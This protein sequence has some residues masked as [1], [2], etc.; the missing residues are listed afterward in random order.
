MGLPSSPRK[1]PSDPQDSLPRGSDFGRPL[2][3]TRLKRTS[4]ATIAKQGARP[5]GGPPRLWEGGPRQEPS[6]ALPEALLPLVCCG[7]LT[8]RDP[9]RLDQDLTFKAEIPENAGNSPDSTRRILACEPS[10][11]EMAVTLELVLYGVT[12]AAP[13]GY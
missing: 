1:L 13:G 3:R 10:V 12:A 6:R 11:R 4:S 5:R 8:Y 7:R 9:V 2:C